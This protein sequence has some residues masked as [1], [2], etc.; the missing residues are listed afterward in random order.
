V[1]FGKWLRDTSIMALLVD[2]IDTAYYNMLVL[3]EWST[4]WSTDM[5][6][7]A[8]SDPTVRR[9]RI[10]YG[11]FVVAAAFGRKTIVC[12]TGLTFPLFE[13]RRRTQSPH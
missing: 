10:F 12:A 3:T 7:A 8:S 13:R 5:A 6:N 4:E 1:V 9:P 2:K 11:W